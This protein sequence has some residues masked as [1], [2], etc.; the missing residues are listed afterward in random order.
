LGGLLPPVLGE[1][2]ADKTSSTAQMDLSA[3]IKRFGEASKV[4]SGLPQTDNVVIISNRR[5]SSNQPSMELSRQTFRDP[6]VAADGHVYKRDTFE[7]WISR[8]QIE[9]LEVKSPVTDEI[10]H[11]FNLSLQ[12]AERK[13]EK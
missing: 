13:M 2:N 4:L 5:S 11:L 1:S 7:Q 9:R 6:V 3:A 12:K 10:L 8:R